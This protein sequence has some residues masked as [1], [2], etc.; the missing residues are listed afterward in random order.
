M[1]TDKQ[2]TIL[3]G[4]LVVIG[5]IFLIGV[6]LLMMVWP[7][8][9]RWQPNQSEYEQMILGV[10]AV[11]GIFLLLA[12]RNPMQH[13]SLLWFTVWSSAVHG[14]IMAVQVLRDPLER[15]HLLGDVPALF[16]VA[17]VLALLMPR[18]SAASA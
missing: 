7:S 5:V 14:G 9:W 11:L 13:R 16:L 3:R 4:V 18:G 2:L 12:A 10:Y 15:G 17:I 1:Q 8:G 6:P